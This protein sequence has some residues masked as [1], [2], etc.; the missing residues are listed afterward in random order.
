[1]VAAEGVVPRQ[2]VHQHRRLLGQ[3][4]HA[5]AHH[6]LVG[7]PHAVRVDDG[8]GQLGR[9]R[10]EQELGDRVGADRVH[11]RV[12]RAASARSRAGRR[13]AW[14]RGRRARLRARTTAS[15]P[16]PRRRSPCRSAAPLANTSPG[17]SVAEDVAQLAVV[18]GDERIGRR[19][20]RERHAGVASRRAPAS[21]A[22]GRFRTGWRPG[23]RRQA[24]VDAAP[25]RSR[26]RSRQ[27]FGV[28]DAAP[29]AAFVL[30]RALGDEGAIGR[31]ARPSAAG[32][33]SCAAG[34][35]RSGSRET[36]ER[37]AV[38]ALLEA[39]R[40]S[41]RAAAGDI[42]ARAPARRARSGVALTPCATLPARPSRKART[43][44]LAPRRSGRSPPSATRRTGPRPAPVGDARQRVHHARSSTAARS[45]RSRSASAN[46]L[47]RPCPAST[48]YCEM[49]IAQPSLA[50]RRRG[51]SASCRSC[52][53][54]RSGA[55]CAPSRRRRR[56]CRAGLRA[57]RRTRCVSATRMW[58][59]AASSR[60]PPTTA[61]C[62]AATTGT[63]PYWI[64]SNA[65]CHMREWTHAP[66]TLRSEQLRRGRG[67]R[68]NDR[69]RR[70]RTA[71]RTCRSGR[72]DEYGVQLR[73]ERI[74]DGVAL[75]RPVQADVQHG[76][77]RLDAQEIERL[78]GER[79]RTAAGVSRRHRSIVVKTLGASLRDFPLAREVRRRPNR[80]PF[81]RTLTSGYLPKIKVNT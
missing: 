62:R 2:P 32:G 77:A 38:G 53:R 39:P 80:G 28:A 26:A 15:S 21:S 64:C 76:P 48:T 6:L 29:V 23:A 47:S 31:A 25:G 51:R 71:A 65:A 14:P 66:A 37:R 4:R 70:S 42:A 79:R 59:A 49:P 46:A 58:Q 10:G 24:A 78:Q 63:G 35:A 40:A 69:P 75:G 45:R 72:F 19:D 18:L 44:V 7:A 17:V 41:R 57:G 81:R 36:H 43:R 9:A 20:R 3:H 8:L 60:P 1:M 5:L 54:R 12:D 30:R 73:D 74:A 56:T 33:R 34:T 67:R 22:P 13:T 52:A 11:G 68:R 27:R 50:R 55:G 16:A 61:P